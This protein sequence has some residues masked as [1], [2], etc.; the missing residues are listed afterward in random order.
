MQ[1]YHRQHSHAQPT[2]ENIRFWCCTRT[3]HKIGVEYAPAVRRRGVNVLEI[4]FCHLRGTVLLWESLPHSS[5]LPT[6][7]VTRLTHLD[8]I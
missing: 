8:L 6:R 3:S 5:L 1:P 2:P 4:Y 7:L